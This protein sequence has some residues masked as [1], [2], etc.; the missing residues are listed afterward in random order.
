MELRDQEAAAKEQL[1][2]LLGRDVLSN[3]KFS[4]SR[5][6]R[7]TQPALAAAASAP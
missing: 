6:R 1:N 5:S 4:P 3:L 7:T 2:Q